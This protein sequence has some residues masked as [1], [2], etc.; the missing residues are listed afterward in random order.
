MIDQAV[1]RA[2][3]NNLAG[4]GIRAEAHLGVQIGVIRVGR[5]VRQVDC[6]IIAVGA[7]LGGDFTGVRLVVGFA[8]VCGIGHNGDHAA[9]MLAAGRIGHLKRVLQVGV[10]GGDQQR[11]YTAGRRFAALLVQLLDFVRNLAGASVRHIDDHGILQW[12]PSRSSISSACAGPHVP[13]R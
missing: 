7:D 5:A 8:A 12:R 11:Q 2:Q 10:V 9:R 6:R 4:T 1:A 13:A 3:N